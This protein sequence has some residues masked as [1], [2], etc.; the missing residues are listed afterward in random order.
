MS[1][2]H[3]SPRP[4]RPRNRARFT[5]GRNS[6]SLAASQC[7]HRWREKSRC[8]QVL[9]AASED[10][11]V[12]DPSPAPRAAL[13][14]VVPDGHAACRSPAPLTSAERYESGIK[15]GGIV[16]GVNP[17]SDEDAAYFE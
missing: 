17:R 10:L 7:A 4:A 12:G 15:E 11:G 9:G 16:M 1:F 3:G 14:R 6:Y 13:A 5:A 2:P 8:K